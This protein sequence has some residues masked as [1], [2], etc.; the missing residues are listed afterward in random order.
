MSREAKRSGAQASIPSSLVD[1]TRL[2]PARAS[3]PLPEL[4]RNASPHAHR[5]RTGL[6]TTIP[7]QDPENRQVIRSQSKRSLP[8]AGEQTE[9]ALHA[10]PRE[11]SGAPMIP[12]RG[13]FCPRSRDGRSLRIAPGSDSADRSP[14]PLGRVKRPADAVRRNIE[15]PHA[16]PGCLSGCSILETFLRAESNEPGSLPSRRGPRELPPDTVWLEYGRD[17]V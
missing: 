11:R 9:D 15:V 16:P 1:S 14:A 6:L 5:R 13:I 3:A 2:Q 10:K 4:R 12:R 8:S 17:T 7:E